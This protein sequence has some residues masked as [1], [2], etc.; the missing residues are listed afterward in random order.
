M[1]VTP[2]FYRNQPVLV[3]GGTGFIGRRLVAALQTQG[4]RIRV[5][6]RPGSRIPADWDSIATVSGDLANAASLAQAC[7]GIHTVFHVAGF[8]HADAADIPDFAVRHWAINT[9]G[10]Y[11]L[12]DAAVIAKVE[13]FVFLSSAKAV[14]APG[15]H[16][17]DEQWEEL[18]ETPYGRSKRAAENHV[19]AIG[20][21][22]GLH[23]VNLRPALVYGPGMTGN[24]TRLIRA[25]QRGGFPPLPETGNR[26]SL[27]HVDDVVQAMLL[28]AAH[29]AATG[30]CYFVT[31]SQP[32]SGR[33][34]YIIIR[35][36]L[37]LSVPPWSVPASLLYA[38]A[39]L[40]DS[41][42]WLVGRKP[43]MATTL[44]K[45]L[46]WACY[47]S[48]RINRELGYQP[49]WTFQRYCEHGLPEWHV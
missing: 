44:N 20:R 8:A 10:T 49:T 15:S 37:G 26:R 32:Y 14:G 11:R 34:L 39:R 46:D 35:R 17:V 48:A 31:D 42:L 9:E 2:D 6:V 5:L 47:D 24:L 43:R 45:L 27:V 30:Q 19:L 13:R 12:L 25:M 3:T 40:A 33:E 7:T 18:P 23:A 28:A 36:A 1:V 22:S 38:V 21:D 4:A 41:G 29:P 16:G